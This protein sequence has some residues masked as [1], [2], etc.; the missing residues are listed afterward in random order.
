M[1]PPLTM[2]LPASRSRRISPL[3]LARR[4]S[5]LRRPMRIPAGV[6]ALVA[7]VDGDTSGI[8]PLEQ[9]P[10]S[11]GNEAVVGVEK[12]HPVSI[13]VLHGDHAF[14]FRESEIAGGRDASSV[15]L[16]QRHP[17]MA[18]ASDN[19]SGFVRR[20]VVDDD[21]PLDGGLSQCAGNGFANKPG[22]VLYRNDDIDPHR[23]LHCPRE[24]QDVPELNSP[25]RC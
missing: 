17:L 8:G 4:S 7:A 14:H 10:N 6:D 20:P 19:L 2:K 15:T 23:Y 5:M 3:G 13:A 1:T 25:G 9:L 18:E 21:D 12:H 16:D 22:A 24:S 11:V